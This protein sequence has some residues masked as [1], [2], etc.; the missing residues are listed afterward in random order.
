MSAFFIVLSGTISLVACQK[1]VDAGLATSIYSYPLLVE[2]VLGKKSR[3]ILEIAIAL[4]QFSFVISHIT[5]LIESCRGTIDNL[6]SVESSIAFYII[7]VCIIYTLLSWVRN[8]AKFSF[9]FIV[10][11]VL[12]IVA[13]IYVCVFAGK[14]FGEQG[15][16]GPDL[17]FINTAG[18]MNTLG[19]SIYCYEGIGIVMPVLSTC[20]KPERFKAMLTYAIITLMILFVGFSEFCYMVWGS[21]LT[22]PIV[23]QMLPEDNVGVILIKFL[24]SLNLICSYPIMIYPAN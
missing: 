6:F 22:E 8:L 20:E 2:K 21:N 13:V 16:K 4:T 10:G 9:T 18:Y 15:G 23:T 7:A 3:V 17:E 1:L 5:F 12:I 14:L 24:F 11:N 19:F